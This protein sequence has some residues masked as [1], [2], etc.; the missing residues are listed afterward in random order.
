MGTGTDSRTVA[1]NA[2]LADRLAQLIR[3]PTV[4][5]RADRD[6]A[7]FARFRTLLSEMYP[8]THRRLDHEL[9]AGGCLLFRWPGAGGPSTLLMAH[10]DVVP[11]T[12]RDWARPPFGGEVD[13]GKIHGRGCLDDK[14][15]LFVILEAVESLL[16]QGLTPDGDVYLSFG[17]DEEI[18]GSHATVVAG[19]LES[20]G[21]RPDLVVDEGGAIV[22]GM[23]PAVAGDLAM[24][25]VAEKGIANFRLTA[26]GR[27]GHAS[28]PEKNGPAVRLA[29]AIVEVDRN[30]FPVRSNPVITEMVRTLAARMPKWLAPVV[31][32][33]ITEP[34]IPR[35]LTRLGGPVAALARTT[36]GVTTLSGS[37]AANVLASEATA[38]LNIR[39]APGETVAATREHLTKILRGTGVTIDIEYGT[40]PVP[41]SPTSGAAYE[42]VKAALARSYPDAQPVPYVMVQASDSRHFAKISRNIYRFMPFAISASQIRSIHGADE[43]LDISALGSGI[44]FYRH[45]IAASSIAQCAGLSALP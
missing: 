36:V 25:G 10:Y 22:S 27:A 32:A 44:Q 35:L 31:S 1:V 23:I 11:V 6:D 16:A 39:I 38:T 41:S 9:V 30:P 37:P 43:S 21:V 5:L 33:R 15:P 19:L 4:S 17:D 14:G 29:R 24:I 12:D 42:R 7:A 13:G 8:L 28:A 18:G 3:V 20:R 40:D 34:L 2:E 26:R 45:L